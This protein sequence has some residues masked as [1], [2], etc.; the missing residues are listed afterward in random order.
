MVKTFPWNI[1]GFLL[2]NLQDVDFP[3]A[4]VN[5]QA[6]IFDGPSGL[7]KPMD[8]PPGGSHTIGS[9]SDVIGTPSEGDVLVFDS[10]QAAYV[11]QPPPAGSESDPVFLAAPAGGIIA[12]DILDW[13]EAHGWGNHAGLYSGVGHNHDSAYAPLTHNHDSEYADILHDHDADYAPI[14]HN[15]DLV[16]SLL[17]HGHAQLHDRQHS[18]TD[19]A[20][21]SFP[22]GATFLRADGVFAAPGGGSD[23][24]TI[25]K[26]TA[27][28]PTSL[29]ANTPVTGLFFTPAAGK[30][31]AVYGAFLLR[32]GTATVGARPGIAWP[33]VAD[34]GAWV[35]A[36]NS[37]TAAAMRIWGARNTQNALSTGLA[38]TVSSHYAKLEALIVS[39]PTPSGNFQVTLAS[40]TAGTT[41]TMKAGSYIMYREI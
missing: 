39:G 15:H 3:A 6:I 37:V 20:D 16:Y 23:P 24:W 28:F 33:T 35:D 2:S 32:T 21:H 40:E 41:V 11:P 1:E 29:A 14:G 4:P 17:G 10:G 36:P 22:G 25:V 34:G 27:D 8:I 7:F 9:H 30:T 5:G 38:D 18:I 26:L 13:D 31:Y 19:L 12:Q